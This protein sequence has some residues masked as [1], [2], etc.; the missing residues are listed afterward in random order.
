M[1][2][3]SLSLVAL[4]LGDLAPVTISKYNGPEPS[5]MCRLAVGFGVVLLGI[6]VVERRVRLSCCTT[7]GVD[8]TTFLCL[9]FVTSIVVSS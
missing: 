8:V 5:W 7:A 2:S 6:T 9:C 1:E 4:C 3:T